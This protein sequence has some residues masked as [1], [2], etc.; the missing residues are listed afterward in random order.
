M[1]QG[2]IG[3]DMHARL[4]FGAAGRYYPWGS[5][6]PDADADPRDCRARIIVTV[7]RPDDLKWLEQ[8]D[9]GRRPARFIKLPPLRAR[10]SDIVE[11]VG[12]E[13]TGG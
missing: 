10:R 4:R 1:T 13:F 6:G 9:D 7:E 8:R 3:R 11:E 12:G 2:A 5:A